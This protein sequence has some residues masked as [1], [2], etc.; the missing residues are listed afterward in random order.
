[1]K[2]SLPTSNTSF[3]RPLG[4]RT[5]ISHPGCVLAL[6]AAVVCGCNRKPTPS[7]QE[8]QRPSAA[9]SPAAQSTQPAP[10]SL[11][12]RLQALQSG[13]AG[14]QAAPPLPDWK[15]I[16]ENAPNPPIPLV[17][18]LVVETAIAESRGDYE[19]FK[20][21]AEISPT[22]VSLSYRSAAPDPSTPAA[23]GAA[24][25]PNLKY[26]SCTRQI[27]VSDLAKAHSYNERFCGAGQ[28]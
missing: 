27:D 17:K 5:R 11:A 14:K 10:D 9:P 18:G 28:T 19:S 13:L 12:A 8:A 23:A 24:Q 26:V 25:E 2:N 6:A 21:V 3:S 7:Q 16:A 1:M 4:R 22:T 20:T 15:P